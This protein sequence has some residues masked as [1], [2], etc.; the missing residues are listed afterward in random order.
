MPDRINAIVGKTPGGLLQPVGVANGIL[1]AGLYEAKLSTH[2]TST[3]IP[4]STQDFDTAPVPTGQV[5]KVSNVFLYIT[6]QT[7]GAVVNVLVMP[8]GEIMYVV[9][10]EIGAW[11]QY[12]FALNGIEWYLEEGQ[13]LRFQGLNLLSGASKIYVIQAHGIT[14][15]KAS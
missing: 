8:A 1:T 14:F 13:Y 6:G 7:T 4:S 11:R 15:R 2:M 10:S 3:N 12:G 5:W 9:S